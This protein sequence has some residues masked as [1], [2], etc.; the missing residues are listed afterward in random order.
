[1]PN[2][3]LVTGGETLAGFALAI[4]AG[5]PLALLVA[6]SSLLRRTLYPAAVRT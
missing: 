5:V 2:A 6:F 4:L 1:M 3:S